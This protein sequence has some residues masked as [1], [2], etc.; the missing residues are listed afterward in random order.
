[1][2][3]SVDPLLI[4]A[5]LRARSVSRGLPQPVPDLGGL[6]LD[7]NLPSE[8]RR[9]LF[10]RPVAGLY[11]LGADITEPRIPLKLCD[12]PETLHSCLPPRWEI[13]PQ[14]FVMICHQA[15]GQQ[16]ATPQPPAGYLLD[17]RT[18]DG[19]TEA[20]V[21]TANGELA[22]NGYA[23][24]YGDT[25]VYDRIV[26]REKHRRKGF[27]RIVMT[28]LAST[29]PAHARQQVLVATREG[30]ELYLSLGWSD[31]APYSSAVIPEAATG[32]H[33]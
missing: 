16:H 33:S 12:T 3:N 32:M 17:L 18:A 11:E 5:W 20:S 31:Y 8:T 10:A 23:A 14:N 21:L 24:H 9:Y 15:F 26:T 27:G 30:R 1:M 19:V 22:A 25:F 28:A 6:R 7:S 4:E 29:R 13:A 2:P